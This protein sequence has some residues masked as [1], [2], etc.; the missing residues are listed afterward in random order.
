MKKALLLLACMATGTAYAQ[1]MEQT[2][3]W[4][5][6]AMATAVNTGF[7]DSR[8]WPDFYK[9]N[10]LWGRLSVGKRLVDPLSFEVAYTR[11]KS[12]LS[13]MSTGKR[14]GEDMHIV[15]GAFRYHLAGGG[16]L[17][18]NSRWDPYLMARGGAVA[19]PTNVHWTGFVGVGGGVDYWFAKK[20]GLTTMITANAGTGEGDKFMQYGLGLRFRLGGQRAVA[21]PVPVVVEAVTEEVVTAPEPQQPVVATEPAAPVAPVVPPT[22]EKLPS[23]QATVHFAF[24]TYELDVLDRGQ[25]QQLAEQLRGRK[26]DKV[27]ISGYTDNIGTPEVNKRFAM[28]RAQN[29]KRYLI[30]QGVQPDVIQIQDLGAADPA[31]NNDSAEGRALNR[32]VQVV[33]DFGH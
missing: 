7:A 17:P 29:V 31:A 8:V 13:E 16:I 30:S 24:N 12:K 20:V 1:T 27:V 18:M 3:P 6:G 22:P 11:G 10:M 9:F 33:V 23:A 32:R 26:V 15:E 5:I 25:L 21:A 2:R 19:V 14:S 4:Y 28:A